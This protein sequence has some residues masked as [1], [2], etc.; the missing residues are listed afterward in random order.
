MKLKMILILIGIALLAFMV[1]GFSKASKLKNITIVKQVTIN[2][3]LDSVFDRVKY[4]KN[5]PK[6]S[7]FLE[8]DPTQKISY[9][10]TDGTV[11]AQYHWEGNKGKDLGFQEIVTIEEGRFVGMQCTIEKPF[12]ASPTFEYTFKKTPSGITVT[13]EFHLESQ[14]MDAFFMGLFGA[15]KEMEKTNQRGLELLKKSLEE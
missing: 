13:Q 1:Y 8:A 12:K 14:L 11:G 6:W 3:E 7:P 15:K 5:F 2:A 9:L 4:L 10:G